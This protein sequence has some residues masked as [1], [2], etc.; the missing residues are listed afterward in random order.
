MLYFRILANSVKKM[1]RNRVTVE[2]ILRQAVELGITILSN[3]YKA[4]NIDGRQVLANDDMFKISVG[5]VFLLKM[6]SVYIVGRY[7][8][9]LVLVTVICYGSLCSQKE[10]RVGNF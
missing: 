1:G 7:P 6:T 9:T 3:R 8:I 4:I 2:W 5:L 10:H